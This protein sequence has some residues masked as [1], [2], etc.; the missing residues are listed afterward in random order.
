MGHNSLRSQLFSLTTYIFV[1]ENIKSNNLSI[2]RT[3]LDN[4]KIYNR[5][6]NE[7]CVKIIYVDKHTA[8]VK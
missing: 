2:D 3:P 4:N 8:L 1:R 7:Y 6:K 5:K